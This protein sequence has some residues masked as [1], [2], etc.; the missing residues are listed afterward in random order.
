MTIIFLQL[1]VELIS[2]RKT[3]SLRTTKRYNWHQKQLEYQLPL[4]P[5]SPGNYSYQAKKSP[6]HYHLKFISHAT[7]RDHRQSHST[8]MLSRGRTKT[9]LKLESTSILYDE[10]LQS[11]HFDVTQESSRTRANSLNNAWA[12]CQNFAIE[13][14]R[15][16]V[17]E[18]RTFSLVRRL[19]ARTSSLLATSQ[20][21]SNA[22]RRRRRRGVVCHVALFIMSISN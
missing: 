7:F 11:Y 8:F 3:T 22:G 18:K 9:Y 5:S 17:G 14:L 19:I 6:T 10:E 20:G 15:E 1:L 2:Q 12:L 16:N 21:N 13:F 4:S